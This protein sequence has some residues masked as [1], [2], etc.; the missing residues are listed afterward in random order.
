MEKDTSVIPKGPYCY[1]ENGVCPYW[2]LNAY[3]HEQENG[4]C[5]YLERGDW[6]MNDDKKW[7]QTRKNGE[8]VEDAELQSAQEI[9]IPMSLLW[10]QCK[11]C[12]INDDWGDEDA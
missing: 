4:Y 6:E 2:S 1:D 10:D 11:E 3:H 12:N 7:R 5:A 9:G 8:K